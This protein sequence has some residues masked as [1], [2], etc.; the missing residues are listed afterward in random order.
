M[1]ASRRTI[2]TPPPPLHTRV[3]M[4]KHLSFSDFHEIV[5]LDFRRSKI[6]TICV[7]L[8]D[9]WLNCYN[10]VSITC[11]LIFHWNGVSSLSDV[12]IHVGSNRRRVWMECTAFERQTFREFVFESEIK[13]TNSQVKMFVNTSMFG[14]QINY[15]CDGTINGFSLWLALFSDAEC[16]RVENERW[17]TDETHVGTGMAQLHVTSCLINRVDFSKGSTKQCSWTTAARNRNANEEKLTKA[18]KY[19]LI[20][21]FTVRRK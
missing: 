9:V 13:V 3:Q 6:K 19:V 1:I 8:R 4:P 12:S 7:W 11:A 18:G 16:L 10:G 15:V 5:P 21:W 20:G 2:R 17:D 14:Y